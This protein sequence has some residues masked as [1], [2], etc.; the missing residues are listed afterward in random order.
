MRHGNAAARHVT[1]LVLGL[2]VLAPASARAQR[3]AL[4]GIVRDSAGSPIANAEVEIAT[5]RMQARTTDDGRFF[6]TR[7]YPGV[8]EVSIRRIGYEPAKARA[9]LQDG[10][11]SV[12]EVILVARPAQLD[13]VD[14]SARERL[15]AG[16]DGF[17]Q[18]RRQGLGTYVTREDID[19]RNTMSVS[20]MLRTVPGIRFISVRGNSSVQ[21]VR[22]NNTSIRRGD[23]APMLWIDGQ[24]AP[25]LEVDDVNL[26]DIE[27]IELYN[28]PS[29]TPM[30]FSQQQKD[31]TCGTIVI[32]S[33]PPPPARV[34]RP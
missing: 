14:I 32:W 22:F 34:A 13:R 8:V 30:Q 2:L 23:C 29:T 16:V 10:S 27:G 15:R 24:A 19:T 7:M 6:I 12:V 33:R 11:V 5:R 4:R 17:H 3:A 21:G 9:R 1:A 20:A 26:P 25:G 31:N 28:G 18:R